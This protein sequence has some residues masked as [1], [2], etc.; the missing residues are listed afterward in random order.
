MVQ[1]CE[2]WFCRP[3]EEEEEGG[4]K[5]EEEEGVAMSRRG[6][7][8]E[9]CLARGSQPSVHQDPG[10]VT[11]VLTSV[12]LEKIPEILGQDWTAS[13]MAA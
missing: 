5:E 4:E 2:P 13:H 3:P 12:V 11:R 7:A 6:M 9:E 8:W 1:P 10:V